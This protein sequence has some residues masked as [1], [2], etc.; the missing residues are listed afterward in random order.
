MKNTRFHAHGFT[1]IELMIVIAII[2]ILA[3][4]AIPSYNSYID[5]AKRV[6]VAE[7]VDIATRFVSDGLA[8]F[9]AELAMNVPTTFPTT[10]ASIINE[11][12]AAGATAPEGGAPFAAAANNATGAVG[13][14]GNATGPGGN[15]GP[16]D[17]I[18]VTTPAYL[19]LTTPAITIFYTQ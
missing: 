18:V 6:K 3:A 4:I 19:G 5:N 2:G 14:A 9:A 10:A 15:W 12:N 11:L 1:L 8:K 17:N 13:I 16:G 7:H